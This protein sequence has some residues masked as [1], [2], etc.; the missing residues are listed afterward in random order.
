MPWQQDDVISIQFNQTL[1]QQDLLN[2]L[3]WRIVNVVG[4]IIMEE[5]LV[6]LID[7]FIDIMIPAQIDS[8]AH[9]DQ[10]VLNETD[11]VSF[12]L[13]DELGVGSIADDG[14]APSYMATGMTKAIETRI[15]RPG[16]IRL[17]GVP[18][19]GVQDNELTPAMTLLYQPI[20]DWLEVE[21]TY[22]DSGGGQLTL[23]PVVVGRAP[24]GSLDLTRV[25]KVTSV[26]NIRLTSQ[27]SRRK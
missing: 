1:Y 2:K 16:G 19:S 7:E 3:F 26:G 10:K 11:G 22:V 27:V 23:E 4:Q 24:D 17:A 15:T 18:S 5:M 12:M 9:T 8:L 6:F 25:N 14:E 21:H 20:A 13:F